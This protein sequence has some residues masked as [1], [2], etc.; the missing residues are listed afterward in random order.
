MITR[1]CQFLSNTLDS[2][3]RE[4]PFRE[5]WSRVLLE[6]KGGITAVQPT[7]TKLPEFQISCYPESQI[8]CC[9]ESQIS[10]CAESLS[11]TPEYI[12][13]TDKN[14]LR[15]ISYQYASI[16]SYMPRSTGLLFFISD[17]VSMHRTWSSPTWIEYP[18]IPH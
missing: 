4:E 17:D 9:T 5:G 14:I 10:C 8:S 2:N 7:H 16:I 12:C 13:H 1:E 3:N 18:L 6:F 15:C 11:K